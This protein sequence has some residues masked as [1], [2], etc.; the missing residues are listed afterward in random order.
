MRT[1]T[2]IKTMQ[3]NLNKEAKEFVKKA[4]LSRPAD[5]NTESILLRLTGYKFDNLT[6]TEQ[7]SKAKMAVAHALLCE[8]KKARMKRFDYDLNRHIALH[9]AGKRLDDMNSATAV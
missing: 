2:D 7:I 8:R 6:S 3:L 1:K 9:Q 4:S 5:Y